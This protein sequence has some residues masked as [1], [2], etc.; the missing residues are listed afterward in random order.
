MQPFT[1]NLN[2]ILLNSKKQSIDGVRLGFKPNGRI[3][4]SEEKYLL[5]TRIKNVT[6]CLVNVIVNYNSIL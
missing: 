4:G 1:C 2:T 6:T 5:S 3:D